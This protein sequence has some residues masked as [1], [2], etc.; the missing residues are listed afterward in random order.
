MAWKKLS[1]RL[2]RSHVFAGREQ[3]RFC[4]ATRFFIGAPLKKEEKSLICLMGPGGQRAVATAVNLPLAGQAARFEADLRAAL[5]TIIAG[6]ISH[7]VTNSL[8]CLNFNIGLKRCR[9][10]CGFSEHTR[11][12][13]ANRDSFVQIYFYA[14]TT[15]RVLAG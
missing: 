9:I 10:S 4:L 7:I 2:A 6:L 8:T 12:S 15:P 11:C 3:N 14:T 5:L 13:N 1:P